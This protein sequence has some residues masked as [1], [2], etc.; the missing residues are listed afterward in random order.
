MILLPIYY[1][2]TGW[3]AID[4][5]DMDFD[6]KKFIHLRYMEKGGKINKINYLYEKKK[7]NY[8]KKII[9]FK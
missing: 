4:I 2:Y 7:H 9:A 3:K 6:K 1:L 5:D 8:E